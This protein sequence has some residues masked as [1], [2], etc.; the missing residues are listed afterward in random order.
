MKNLFDSLVKFRH[1]LLAAVFLIAGMVHLIFPKVFLPAIP[2]YFSDPILVIYL[3]GF[4][5]I[6]LAIGLLFR[7]SH[8]A[9]LS[10]AY[11]TALIPVHIYV[12]YFQIEIFAINN[13][14]LL[15]SRTFFQLFFIF[16]AYSC[17]RVQ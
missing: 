5:E 4:F 17:R 12:S 8:F 10:A 2:A 11:L 6:I 3:T 7:P 14:Y 9:L 13:P 16:W 1:Y 15:W